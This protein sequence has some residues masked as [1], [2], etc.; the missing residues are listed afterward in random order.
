MD[1]R[2]TYACVIF[3]AS[4]AVGCGG[5]TSKIET[6]PS[7]STAPTNPNQPQPNNPP[8]SAV[9]PIEVAEPVD[10]GPF[11]QLSAEQAMT[12]AAFDSPG[13]DSVSKWSFSNGSEFPGATGTLASANTPWGQGA[14]LT[15]DLSCGGYIWEPIGA[16][17]CGRYVAMLTTSITTPPTIP[18]QDTPTLA[19]DLRNVQATAFP[20][21]RVV[22]STG[23]TLQFKM[24]ARSLENW[25]GSR[26]QTTLTPIGS[27]TRFWGGAA[28][29]VLHPPV[30]SISI[31][32][33]DVALPAPAGVLEVDNIT[34]LP[35]PSSTYTLTT[36]PPLVDR[37]YPSTYVGRLGVVWRPRFG[38]TALDKMIEVGLKLVRFDITWGSVERNGQFD[39]SHYTT[40]AQEMAKRNVKGLFLLVYGHPDHG[41]STP[42][43]D[44]DRSAYGA[45][46]RQA[47]L[48]FKPLNVIDGFEVWNEPN[49]AG[50]WPGQ[51]PLLYSKALAAAIAGIQ[52]VDANIPIVTGGVASTDFNYLSAVLRS[53][54][55]TGASALGVHPYRQTGPETFAAEL[56]PLNQLANAYGV[57]LPWWDTEWGYSSYGDVG[58]LAAVGDG[59]D[60]RAQ[61]RQG[62]MV[63][64]KM[65]TAIAL[66]IPRSFLY[67]AMDEG[68]NP[69]NREHNF[70]L[71]NHDL[72]DKPAMVGARSLY[73]AQRGRSLRGLLAQTPP[74]LHVVRWDGA[75]D[76]V[77]VV[78][79]DAATGS[80]TIK[81]PANTL[82][83]TLWDGTRP[84]PGAARDEVTLNEESGPLFVTIKL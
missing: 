58:T 54:Y 50:F 81:L 6:A 39:F 53:G 37:P 78:W 70:G 14:A 24:P 28:D 49:L 76:R 8:S 73:A 16:K 29:G 71:L 25:D 65:L 56:S 10:T 82:T 44:A 21:L 26:W 1:F 61:R 17:T 9:T 51:D 2:L 40:A 7:Q 47:A 5:G 18:E 55:V 52:S 69:S 60:P 66:N 75:S 20:G 83:A 32:A 63:L 31:L 46:A 27:S 43:T 84:T 4:L 30:R 33:G 13:T 80:T 38:Y 64:R 72:S 35:S 67:E 41:G 15:Y 23:Q 36:N 22:D 34:Y 19:I 62:I 74:G 12:L 11:W 45:Y 57:N 48:T 77:F 79:S 59:H 3:L 42:V 68:T